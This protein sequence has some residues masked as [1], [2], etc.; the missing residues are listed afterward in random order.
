M[1]YTLV[2][3]RHGQSTWNNLNLFTGWVDVPLSEKGTQEAKQAGTLLK[4]YSIYPEIVYTSWL[5][6]SINT[7]NLCLDN[8]DRHWIPVKRAWE[9]NERH[10][11]GLQGKNKAEAA[12]KFG[13]EQVHIWR[14]SYDIRPPELTD[15][16]D[17]ASQSSQDPDGRYAQGGIKVPRTE[18]L[19]D[20]LE[21]AWPYWLS[22]ILP[23][24]KSGKTVLVAAHGNSLRAIIKG[25]EGISDEDI[26]NLELPTG[27]PILYELDESLK[28]VGNGGKGKLLE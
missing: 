14:R 21:R 13:E 18:C 8:S 11:G 23:D 15:S 12:E 4:K 20:V 10:Y 27:I 22:D 17:G 25:L 24:L 3:L 7:A 6:R 19:K 5:R 26:P 1:P 9:L 16:D 2:L 28:V